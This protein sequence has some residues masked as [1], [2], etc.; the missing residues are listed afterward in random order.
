[1]NNETRKSGIELAK[2]V[3]IL[4]I[5]I[6][7]VVLSISTESLSLNETLDFIN[8]NSATTN[9]NTFI[10]I[11][12]RYLGSIGNDIFLISSIWFLCESNK[13]KLNKIINIILDVWFISLLFFLYYKNMRYE[14]TVLETLRYLLPTFYGNN[15]YVTCYILLYAIHPLLNIVINNIDKKQHSILC[16]TTM[17]IY[18]GLCLLSQQLYINSLLVFIVIYFFIAYIK[19]Y[20]LE[21]YESSNTKILLGSIIAL[22]VLILVTDIA[23]LKIPFLVNEM[24]KWDSINNPIIIL[25]SLS[26]FV[27]FKNMDFKS[28]LINY[29]SGLSLFIYLIHENELLV[30]HSRSELV[31]TVKNMLGM[32]F[33]P[34]VVLGISIM[35]FIILLVIAILYKETIGRITKIISKSIDI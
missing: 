8:L 33:S 30:K 2:I 15:W 24:Q 13:T 35:F 22:L 4:L 21:R 12:F 26:I 19:K 7:H 1:M 20:C 14:I 32:G 31:F 11:V 6:S 16:A 23:G 9:I 28:K 3:A 10:L 25:M 34:I 29:V 27:A 5:V 18:C 17:I